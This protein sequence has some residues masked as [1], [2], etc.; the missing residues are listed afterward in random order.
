MCFLNA[1][2]FICGV[3][4][5]IIWIADCIYGK[6]FVNMYHIWKN[7]QPC[8]L[9][10]TLVLLYS[11]LVP[12]FLC[13]LSLAR[14]MV[15][16]FP[17]QSKFKSYEFVVKYT[18][19]GLVTLGIIVLSMVIYLGSQHHIPN[20][21]CLPF[22]DP[23][24]T[25]P[26]IKFFTG[27]VALW[28]F[29]VSGFIAIVYSILV[30]GL[31]KTEKTDIL[32]VK[33]TD[34]HVIVQLLFLSALHIIC[35]LPSNIIFITLLQLPKYPITLPFWTTVAVVPSNAIV[36]PLLFTFLS[37]KKSKRIQ[38]VLLTREGTRSVIEI[39]SY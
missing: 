39:T 14:L 26:E 22:V 25:V 7:G 30:D 3:Y 37:Q 6:T 27:I 31:K 23:D 11:F 9:A 17:L 24:H 15:V 5:V 4:L 10:F 12:Y 1:G 33:R 21:L 32:E 16:K 18:K 29:L 28:Q 8:F 2:D 13:L 38:K 19:A 20:Y 36:N 34:K 35:F